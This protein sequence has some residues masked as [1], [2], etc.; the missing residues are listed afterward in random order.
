MMR[1]PGIGEANLGAVSGAVTGAVGG[2]LAVGI[3]LAIAGRD[4]AL[5][6]LFRNLAIIGFLICVPGGWVLGGQFGPRLGEGRGEIFGGVVGGLL[7][8]LAI[9]FW[10]WARVHG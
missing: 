4:P 6:V 7:P 5:L 1:K 8:V 9:M 2:L 10:A 3:P